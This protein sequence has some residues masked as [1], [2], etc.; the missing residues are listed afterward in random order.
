[1]GWDAFGL[2]AENAAIDRK[3]NPADWT[4]QNIIQ[5]KSQLEKLGFSFNWDQVNNNRK[6]LSKFMTLSC[7]SCRHALLITTSGHNG[8]F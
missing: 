5:M 7:R 4:H 1:M 3:L 6:K 2:P 8:Y